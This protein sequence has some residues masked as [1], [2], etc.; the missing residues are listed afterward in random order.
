MPLKRPPL[1][2]LLIYQSFIDAR[3]SRLF[4]TQLP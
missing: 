1:R 2:K 4:N 3:L